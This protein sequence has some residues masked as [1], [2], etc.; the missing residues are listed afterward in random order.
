MKATGSISD[1]D[2]YSNVSVVIVA[3]CVCKIPAGTANFLMRNTRKVLYP[4]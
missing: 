2:V 3:A 1:S 4:R